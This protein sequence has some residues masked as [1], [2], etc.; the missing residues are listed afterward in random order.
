MAITHWIDSFTVVNFDTL[1][2]RGTVPPY[3]K[4]LE[5]L[6]S[7]ATPPPSVPMEHVEKV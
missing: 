4:S 3:E 5:M 1:A 6:F 2:T 7:L